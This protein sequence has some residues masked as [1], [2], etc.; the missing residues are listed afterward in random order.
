MRGPRATF[1]RSGWQGSDRAQPLH[2]KARNPGELPS[3]RPIEV[4]GRSE[5]IL[6]DM[7]Q[8]HAP[9]VGPPCYSKARSTLWL[10]PR[11]T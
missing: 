10:R 2:E 4:Q 11:Q 1:S 5:P 8:T 9:E 6:L 7:D 3:S